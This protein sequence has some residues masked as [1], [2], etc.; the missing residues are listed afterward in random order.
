M[1]ES[2]D[3]SNG[4]TLRETGTDSFALAGALTFDSVPSVWQ[5]GRRLFQGRSSITL[6]LTQVTRADSAGLALMVEWMREANLRKAAIHFRNIP[7][8]MLA[9]ARTSRLE[10]LLAQ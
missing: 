1:R 9:I 4:V 2:Q 7:S 3:P 10:H 6:D 8:Q 5:E